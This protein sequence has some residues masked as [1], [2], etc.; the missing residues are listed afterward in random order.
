[1]TDYVAGLIYRERE[2][3]DAIANVPA[4]AKQRREALHLLHKE[5]GTWEKV[6]DATNQKLPT[7]HK[8]ASQPRKKKP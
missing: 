5:L 4:W 3:R 2:A 7:V 1:M 8:A 6:A